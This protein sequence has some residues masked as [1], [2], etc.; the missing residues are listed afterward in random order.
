VL[1]I[2][3]VYASHGIVLDPLDIALWGLP[4]ALCAFIIHALRLRRFSRRWQR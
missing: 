3:S 4:T 1:L 2:H